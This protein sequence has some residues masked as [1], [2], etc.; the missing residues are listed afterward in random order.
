M[1]WEE[2]KKDKA[3]SRFLGDG[4]KLQHVLISSRTSVKQSIGRVRVFFGHAATVEAK[5]KKKTNARMGS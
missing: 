3:S 5:F 2:V 1:P 4:R